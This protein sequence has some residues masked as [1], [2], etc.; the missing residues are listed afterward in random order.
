MAGLVRRP[1]EV[2]QTSNLDCG[3]AA[4][5]S[6]LRGLGVAASYEVLRDVC[7][8]DVDGTSINAVETVARAAGALVEQMV[9]PAEQL[10]ALPA[11][12]FPA[13]A[14][15]VLPDGFTHF[16]VLWRR[17]RGRVL[18][19]DPAVGRRWVRV[20]GL[21]DELYRHGTVVPAAA[22]RDWAGSDVFLAGLDARLTALHF[23]PAERAEWISRATADPSP[24]GLAGLDAAIRD[25]EPPGAPAGDVGVAAVQAS[26]AWSASSGAEDRWS[27]VPA[28]EGMVLLRGAVI[29]RVRGW[30]PAAADPDLMARL[31]VP[32]PGPVGVLAGLL[33]RPLRLLVGVLAAG[34]VAGGLAVGEDVALRPLVDPD[35]TRTHPGVAVAVVAVAAVAGVVSALAA[36]RAGRRVEAVLRRAWWKAVAM[37]P[38]SFITTRPVSD[39]AERGHLLHRVRELPVTGSR[40]VYAVGV[41]ACGTAVI[42]VV[43][44]PGAIWCLLGLLAVVAGAPVLAARRAAEADLRLRTLAGGLA[45]FGQDGLLGADAIRSVGA[46]PALRAEHERGLTAWQRAQLR[47]LSINV[48]TRTITGGLGALAAAGCVVMAHAGVGGDL[49]IAAV[50]VGMVDAGGALADA[51]R[52]V[53]VSR[54]TMARAAGPLRIAA[55]LQPLSGPGLSE[56]PSVCLAG[57]GVQAGTVD[58]LHNITLNIPAGTHVA[59]VGRS[60]SGKST[61]LSVLLGWTPPTVGQVLLDGQPLD[62]PAVRAAAGWASPETRLWNDTITVNVDYGAADAARPAGQRL[63]AAEVDALVGQVASRPDPHLGDGGGGVS[64]GE[65]QRLRFARALGR[66]DAPLVILDEPFIGLEQQRRRRL[67]SAARQQWK[68]S[69][70]VCA[71]HDIADS[72]GFDMVIVLDG[73]TVAETGDPAALAANPG[74]RY[75]ALLQAEQHGFAV[76][77]AE[78]NLD[79][80]PS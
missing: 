72:L 53:P 78:L 5:A 46:A 39:L 48:S 34:L 14:V 66:P 28:D 62:G 38:D 44:A 13:I 67:L 18:V 56:P 75:G 19:M 11:E 16:V 77:W 60:G 80:L 20:D 49:L 1:P 31:G 37:L 33:T 47:L 57:V 29:V 7:A 36:F 4:L 21:R 26:A 30:D 74:S 10:L 58:V 42:G 71:L 2:I 76:G 32:E 6:L 22:W 59:L 43:A 70:L 35:G 3:P 68:A 50:A 52:T 64:G 65:G 79:G 8:T 69:T 9:V 61:L 27:C 17:Q 51:L 45:R 12:Y 54:S 40:A 73:G 25:A 41:I 23:A 15:T 55:A 63:I 24:A